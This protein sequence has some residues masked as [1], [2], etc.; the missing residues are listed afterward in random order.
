MAM[1]DH[2]EWEL[3]DQY[4]KVSKVTKVMEVIICLADPKTKEIYSLERILPTLLHEFAHCITPGSYVYGHDDSGKH[5][6]KWNFTPHDDTFYTKFA[7][8]LDIAEKLKIYK[9]PPPFSKNNK[10]SLKRFD[11]VD[12]DQKNLFIGTSEFLNSPTSP[13]KM[14]TKLK[15]NVK[16]E[17][18]DTKLVI[19]EN[20]GE[21]RVLSELLEACGKKFQTKKKKVVVCTIQG[22]VLEN[23]ENLW[24]YLQQ[25]DTIL[26]RVL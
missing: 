10:I 11:A 6:R 17:K 18:G 20:I 9:L 12:V 16:N 21:N 1:C 7:H 22:D 8:I 13:P 5:K 15:I 26:L 14:P 4:H 2:D 19:L 3:V 25:N 23:S 24:T